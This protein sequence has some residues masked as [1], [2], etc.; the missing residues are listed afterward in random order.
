MTNFMPV[1]ANKQIQVIL[2]VA[3]DLELF[4]CR[5]SGGFRT[6]VPGV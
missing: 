6:E 4:G 2:H 5:T 3:T 1:E